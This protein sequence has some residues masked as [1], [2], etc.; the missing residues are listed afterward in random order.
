MHVGLRQGSPATGTLDV[1]LHRHAGATLLVEL[2][3]GIGDNVALQR[4]TA[5]ALGD[6][7]G[8][9]LEDLVVLI[10]T[11]D[12]PEELHVSRQ[13]SLGLGSLEERIDGFHIALAGITDHATVLLVQHLKACQQGVSLEGF[14]SS[15]SGRCSL[16]SLVTLGDSSKGFVGAGSSAVGSSLSG[17][18]SL[19]NGLLSNR[20]GG[21]G[22][23]AL[24]ACSSKLGVQLDEEGHS[25]AGGIGLPELEVGRTLEELTHAVGLLDTGELHHDATLLTL[26]GLDVGLHNAEAVDTCADD[27]EG[28][29]N[30]CLHLFAQHGLHLTV[31]ALGVHLAAQLL[32]S[33][34]LGEVA[35]GRQCLVVLDEKRDEIA[36][37]GLS[38]CLGLFNGL[39]E[40]GIFFVI[41]ERLD[42]IGHTDFEDDVHTTLEVQTQTDT[43]LAALLE[44]PNTE[45]DGFVSERVQV[46]LTSGFALGGCNLL[47]LALIVADHP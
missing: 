15:G 9:E 33:E 26:K 25:L 31:G 38:L 47:G 46:V 3:L 7:N 16:L 41:G 4:S 19:G 39:I 27:V 36:L 28:V 2:V 44:C 8:I 18:S 10:N 23:S 13:N 20:G 29:I 6:L 30:G 24:Y 37:T 22:V 1:H 34:E 35:V 5:V 40:V 11:L 17:L 12:T 32:R 45:I 43:H 21:C 42:H 14:L